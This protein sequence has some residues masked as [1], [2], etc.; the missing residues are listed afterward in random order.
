MTREYIEFSELD[1]SEQAWYLKETWCD[2]CDKPDLGINEPVMYKENGKTF[3][4]GK[5]VVCGEPQTSQVIT[6]DVDG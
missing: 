5:C 1:E 3:V 2:K 4:S 6:K